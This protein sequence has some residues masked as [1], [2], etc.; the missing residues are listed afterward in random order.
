[1]TSRL[2]QQLRAEE[3]ERLVAYQ[4]HLGYWTIGVGRLLD[5]RKGGGISAEESEY[6]LQNDIARMTA[7]VLAELPWA[8]NL[9]EPRLGALVGMAFQMGPA[10]LFGFKQTLSAI[11]D[12]R[13]AHAAALMMQS[14]WATQTPQRARRMARQIETGE[15]QS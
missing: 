7:A 3:G 5:G 10:G 2:A 13:Y 14:K 1:M 15:W 4:D 9:T 6:L 8:K 11:R 12:E